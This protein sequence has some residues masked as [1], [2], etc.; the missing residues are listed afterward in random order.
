MQLAATT[1]PPSDAEV[2]MG[3][4]FHYDDVARDIIRTD[5]VDFPSRN[6][7]VPPW[8]SGTL[9]GAVAS[10]CLT[11]GAIAPEAAAVQCPVLVAM[12]SGTS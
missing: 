8:G 5:L 3:W 10:S 7:H 1:A 9:P 12:A 11:P 6:G 2:T 4:G